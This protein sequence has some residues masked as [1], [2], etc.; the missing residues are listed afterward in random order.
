MALAEP[1]GRERENVRGSHREHDK[2]IRVLCSRA[3]Q[4]QPP[5]VN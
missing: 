5:Y 3:Y 2:P 1:P 4:T